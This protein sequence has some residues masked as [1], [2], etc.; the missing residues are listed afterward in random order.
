MN[1]FDKG[2]TFSDLEV[3]LLKTGNF[4]TVFELVKFVYSSS[5]DQVAELSMVVVEG[6]EHGNEQAIQILKQAGEN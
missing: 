4:Q 3:S 5:K 6:A 2:Q 1:S